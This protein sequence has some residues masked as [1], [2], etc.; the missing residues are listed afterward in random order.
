M[1]LK[2]TQK[3]K[4]IKECDQKYSSN[5]K[6]TLTYFCESEEQLKIDTEKK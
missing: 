3:R 4:N 2:L 5:I 1:I 6:K